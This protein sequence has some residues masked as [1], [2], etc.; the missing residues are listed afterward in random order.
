MPREI[1]IAS[2]LATVAK[3]GAAVTYLSSYVHI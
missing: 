3:S 2:T 1:D